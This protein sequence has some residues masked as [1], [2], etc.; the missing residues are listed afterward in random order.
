MSTPTT[1]ALPDL[2]E[3]DKREQRYCNKCGYMGCEED[4][5]KG[6]TVSGE[7]C[8][9]LAPIVAGPWFTADQMRD[10]AR[11]ALAASAGEGEA[12]LAAFYE[13]LEPALEAL[14][15]RCNQDGAAVWEEVIS[16]EA[17]LERLYRAWAGMRVATPSVHQDEAPAISGYQPTEGETV[18]R[19][20]AKRAINHVYMQ[21]DSHRVDEAIA[22]LEPLPMGGEPVALGRDEIKAIA[23]R[24][25]RQPWGIGSRLQDA[26]EFAEAVLHEAKL[27]T[28]PTGG[29]AE[30][31]RPIETA[32][33]D[34]TL[35]RLLVKFENNAIEDT[36]EPTATIGH[37]CNGEWN[38]VGWD[39][40][41]DEWA[42]GGGDLLGWLPMLAAAPQEGSQ[43]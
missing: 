15:N 27:Y 12:K 13:A 1:K 34:N 32:P 23:R 10:Y 19:A 36:E 14:V 26:V 4:H 8:F 18:T 43:P 28:S 30:G 7:R 39:W 25:L 38:F 22:M 33:L 42:R 35:V 40:H 21:N 11:A 5:P 17:T 6:G 31:W 16:A 3:P 2:P 9:Y 41:R 24:L 37:C 29:A 20:S